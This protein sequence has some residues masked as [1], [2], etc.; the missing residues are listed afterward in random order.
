VKVVGSGER[1]GEGMKEEWRLEKSLSDAR[2]LTC[3]G[4][5]QEEVL[6]RRRRR[7]RGGKD[8]KER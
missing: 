3:Q 5:I 7:R 6:K 1:D 8:R 2:N 4:N